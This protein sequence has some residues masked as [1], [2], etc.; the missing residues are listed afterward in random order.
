MLQGNPFFTSKEM[1][2][3]QLFNICCSFEINTITEEL[4][5]VHFFILKTDTFIQSGLRSS[6]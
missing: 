3:L 2:G 1:C 4:F 6:L 5:L